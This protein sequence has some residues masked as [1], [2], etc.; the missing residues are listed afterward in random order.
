MWGASSSVALLVVCILS[1]CLHQKGFICFP[2]LAAAI[3]FVTYDTLKQTIPTPPHLAPVNHMLSASIGE[4]VCP[5]HWVSD[6]RL[7]LFTRPL[8]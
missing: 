2:P 6:G 3:F 1:F 5:Q 4:V 7:T 8:V